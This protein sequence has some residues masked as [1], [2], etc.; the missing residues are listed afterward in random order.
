MKVVTEEI[1]HVLEKANQKVSLSE[2]LILLNRQQ[3]E[4]MPVL[5]IV[6]CTLNIPQL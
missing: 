4:D 3:L 6:T 1:K 5:G 2:G